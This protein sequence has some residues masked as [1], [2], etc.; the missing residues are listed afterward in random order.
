M[1]YDQGALGSRGIDY[2]YNGV[3]F[4]A[5]GTVTKYFQGPVGRRGRLDAVG[6]FPSTTFVGVTTPNQV[7][8]GISGALTKFASCGIF[9]STYSTGLVPAGTPVIY[10]ANVPL[11]PGTAPTNGIIAA[12]PTT[13]PSYV[14]A[15][16][17]NAWLFLPAN[18]PIFVSFL[19]QT[20]ASAG[21]ADVLI[22]VTWF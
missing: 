12:Y 8:I 13:D 9:T 11:V 5:A 16:T 7:N 22:S 19:T 3:S 4:A 10:D 17:E 2:G 18:T 1:S 6:I 20:G 14:D 21:V 15:G